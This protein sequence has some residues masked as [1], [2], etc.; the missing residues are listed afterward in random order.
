MKSGMVPARSL[1]FHLDLS[2]RLYP[3]PFSNFMI[4]E[5]LCST[6]PPFISLRLPVFS[7]IQYSVRDNAF[8]DDE[9]PDDERVPSRGSYSAILVASTSRRLFKN[10]ESLFSV[11]GGPKS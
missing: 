2:H 11:S 5:C 8:P 3:D 9:F 10:A 4:Y 6:V 7:D 1:I